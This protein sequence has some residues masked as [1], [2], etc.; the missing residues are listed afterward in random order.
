MLLKT[1]IK[2]ANKYGV[3]KILYSWIAGA[4]WV[5]T[6]GDQ[7][8]TGTL[9]STCAA[10]KYFLENIESWDFKLASFSLSFKLGEV[11]RN[12]ETPKQMHKRLQNQT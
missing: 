5:C 12:G 4:F 7:A 8:K 9:L 11:E 3:Q 6:D 2:N 1:I 10:L